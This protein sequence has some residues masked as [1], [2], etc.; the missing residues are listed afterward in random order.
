[1]AYDDLD[2]LQSLEIYVRLAD[3]DP[4]SAPKALADVLE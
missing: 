4:N 2:L 3:H 1:M